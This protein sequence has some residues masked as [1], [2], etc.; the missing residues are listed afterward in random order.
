MSYGSVESQ[1]SY[2]SKYG[3]TMQGSLNMNG[4][5]LTGLPTPIDGSDAVSLDYMQTYSVGRMVVGS[6]TGNG[7]SNRNIALDFTPKAV[8]VMQEGTQTF[9]DAGGTSNYK[10]LGG[11]AVTN[12][13]A[14]SPRSEYSIRITTNGFDVN[15]DSGGAGVNDR[16]MKYNYIAFG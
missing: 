2:V 9:F 14:D 4:N 7:L 13:V 12:S 10:S 6:Y 8:I 3:D 5:K 11:L 15:T 16:G 1:A